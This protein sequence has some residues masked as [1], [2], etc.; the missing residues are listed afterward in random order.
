MKSLLCCVFLA[1]LPA[2]F[3]ADPA[4][5]FPKPDVMPRPTKQVPPVYPLGLRAAGVVGRVTVDAILD[6]EGKVAEVH[7]ARS[8]NPF[9]ERPAIEAVMQ[10]RFSPAL[11]GGKPVKTRIRQEINF[12]LDG[13]NSRDLWRIEPPRDWGKTP[14][15]LRWAVAPE[16]VSTLM[17]AYPLEALLA[18]KSGKVTL[19]YLIDREGRVSLTKVRE[20]TA[21]E[22]AAAVVAMIDGWRFKPARKADGTA[23][24]AL[25]TVVREFSADGRGD[26]PVSSAAM[27]AADRLRKNKLASVP[28]GELDAPPKAVSQRPPIYPTPLREAGA[29]GEAT[30][31]FFID[32]NGDALLPRVVSASA[33]EFGY[34]SVQAV[35]TWRFTAPQKAGKSVFARA[36][37]TLKFHLKEPFTP[38]PGEFVP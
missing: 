14:E 2:I 10:W 1:A 7:I 23:A 22:F 26:V 21:P 27:W 5:E 8:N 25:V 6:T 4:K 20:A 30:V 13:V 29:D 37:Q 3:A 9:F 11:K 34:A 33:P 15:E 12:Q 36:Q 38:P 28:L 31:E 32:E 35:A 18:K 19:S 16:P 17:A 24:M